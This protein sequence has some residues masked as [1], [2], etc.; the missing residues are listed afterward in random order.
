MIPFYA[1]DL[2]L[3]DFNQIRFSFGETK[4]EAI[5]KRKSKFIKYS[6]FLMHKIGGFFSVYCGGGFGF[7]SEIRL[8][9]DGGPDYFLVKR[10]DK[11]SEM[12]NQL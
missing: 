4:E 1:I 5:R 3:F 11:K 2:E 8:C 12:G 6:Y 9:L 10:F 7:I